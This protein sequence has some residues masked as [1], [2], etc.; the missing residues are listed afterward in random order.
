MKIS[1]NKGLTVEILEN[2]AVR[3]I[4]IDKI[5]IGMQAGTPYSKPGFNIFLRKRSNGKTFRPLTGPES[6]NRFSAEKD[7]FCVCGSWD[8][9]DYTVYLTF[10]EKVAGWA[11][12]IELK[13]N[14]G[15]EELDLVLVQDLGLKPAGEGPNN[16]YY[17]SQYLERTI[18][19]DSK[20]GKVLLARQNMKEECGFPFLLLATDGV[21]ASGS[22]DGIDF[23]G[24]N[25]RNTGIPQGL[26]GETL[27]GETAGEASLFALQSQ[28]FTLE[29]GVRKKMTFA[30][31]YSADHRE[32]ISESDL[33]LLPN[34]FA[35]FAVANPPT[36]ACQAAPVTNMF[37]TAPLLQT[38]ELSD[39]DTAKYFGT[40]YRQAEKASG[41]LLSF[42]TGENKH[43]VF[44]A[45]ELLVDRPHAHI[46]QA[47]AAYLPDENIMSTT[48]FAFGVF[49]SHITQGNTNF[50]TL[51]SV[52]TTQFFS[53]TEAGQRIFVELDGKFYLLAVPS[54]F[55][56]GLNHGRWIYKAGR[57]VLEVRSWTSREE[58]RIN[59]D[60]KV[61]EGSPVRIVVTHQFD[62]LNKWKVL[63]GRDG[64]EY[65]AVPGE[66]TMI[67]TKFSSPR[68]RILVNG[69]SEVIE[70]GDE[71]LIYTGNAISGY[72][73]FVIKTETVNAFSLSCIGELIEP[74]VSACLKDVDSSFVKDTHDGSGIFSG[75]CL[76][77]E[78]DSEQEDAAA[79]SEILPWYAVNALTHYQ[80]PY[81]LEQF[82]GAAWGT[83]DVS[84]GPLDLLLGMEKYDAAR[85]VLLRIFSNQNSDGGW[86]QWWMF[87][88][89][90]EIRA[91]HS[92]GDVFYW[93]L[94]AL[95]DYIMVTGDR[96]ILSERIPYYP[97]GGQPA[98]PTPLSE[99]VDRL[100]EMIIASFL[101]G[102][103]FVP[104]G[105][106]DWN[107]SLQPVSKKLAEQL[108]SSWTVEMNYQAFNQYRKVFELTGESEKAS[109][110]EKIC[111]DIRSD[112]NTYLVKDG[113][114]AGYGR[115]EDDGTISVLLHPSD[116]LTGI[117]YS[118]LPMDRGVISGI[119]TKEQA[120][121]HQALIE[122]HLKGPDGARLMDKPLKYKG[123]IQEIFQ[124]AESSTFFG[125]EIG[126]M[127]VHEH[128][129]YAESQAVTGKAEA[130]VRALRQAIPVGYREVVPCGDY[131]QANCY[132]SSS[133]VTFSTRY[134]A[135]EKYED[136][137]NGRM[138]L[139]GGW[140]VY[141]SGPGIYISLVVSRL[142]GVRTRAGF[143]VF[144]PVMPKGMDGLKAKLNWFGYPLELLYSVKERTFAPK[145]LTLNGKALS[146]RRDENSYREGGA[147]IANEEFLGMLNKEKNLLLI[148]L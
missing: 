134:E 129:R 1:N 41:S 52:C 102:T 148:E 145:G 113:I 116:T 73:L 25:Y 77:L 48:V 128:I 88:S 39:A 121:R 83:R 54:A 20:Y 74:S 142:L 105:G 61:L 13:N 7:A 14:T 63:P 35:E 58:N 22:T 68:Y 9:L 92:H 46:F 78:I 71:S 16:E 141:S 147:V 100:I 6:N 32:A 115:K 114:V 91:D 107:D 133:D 120:E 126:L 21:A 146:F 138:L 95:S 24:K 19:D 101:P 31:L 23:Y 72:P 59:M 90:K 70:S 127:Y 33:E 64:S 29:S 27:K 123:G 96:D 124:R 139:K 79:I 3:S 30:F 112:F 47:K 45:K 94:M 62:H 26:L 2:G 56:M 85:E 69:D 15:A 111:S 49:N 81:G 8:G 136:V 125:R 66:G 82:S 4:E 99:H 131:R 44:K 51:L 37:N 75:L 67:T 119:F 109:R 106:G 55:E 10:A 117:K 110:L 53:G 140:R 43:V 28:P 98:D 87:D 50:S 11:W 135:D 143:T 97:A 89:F 108:I 36:C 132:Y 118:L 65:L 130:F 86:A 84:Q 40:E 12:T 103:S 137:I 93:C 34:L 57:H 122:E 5:R 38:E 60:V 17:A 104:F 80:T 42:F 76:G 18:L 144:D